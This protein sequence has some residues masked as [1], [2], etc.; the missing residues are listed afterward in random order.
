[1][2][3]FRR[4]LILLAFGLPLGVRAQT[5]LLSDMFPLAHQLSD[6]RVTCF[7]EDRFGFVWIGTRHGLNRFG[8]ATYLTYYAGKDSLSLSGDT[9][10]ALLQD[11]D[12]VWIGD[13]HGVEMI[14][15]G[16]VG[17]RAAIADHA[18]TAI[19]PLDEGMLVISDVNG[20]ALYDKESGQT[21]ASYE[22][23]DVSL[24]SAI[25]VTESGRVWVAGQK[26]I[27]FIFVFDKTLTLLRTLPLPNGTQVNGLEVLD[28][29]VYAA[30]TRG[31]CRF[32]TDG[33]QSTWIPTPSCGK[34]ILF[35]APARDSSGIV[36]GIASEGLRL[37]DKRK[38]WKT[39]WQEETLSGQGPYVC[40]V[41][42]DLVWLA[43]GRNGFSYEAIDSEIL[44]Y[45][46]P[47]EDSMVSISSGAE[48]GKVLVTSGRSVTLFDPAD[49]SSHNIT[50]LDI[51]P[52]QIITASVFDPVYS[53]LWLT[54]SDGAL[55]RYYFTS[56]SLTLQESYMLPRAHCLWLSKDGALHVIHEQEH[57]RIDASASLTRTPMGA[58][59]DF[60]TSHIDASG[61][62]YLYG[63][64]GIAIAEPDGSFRWVV[65]EGI[66]YVSCL[67]KDGRGRLWAGSFGE[68]L[69]CI[70][71][72]NIT[73]HLTED[74]GLPDL[75]VRALSL[76]GNGDLWVS[77]RYQVTKIRQTDLR[78]SVYDPSRHRDFTF[79]RACGLPLEDGS[80]LF[81]GS[82]LFFRFQPD[83]RKV[84]TAASPIFDGIFI[85]GQKQ[86]KNQGVV[87]RLPH[88]RN[89]VDFYYS[90]VD[91]GLRPGL[92]YR[93]KLEGYDKDWI[94]ASSSQR[95]GY[96]R[97]PAGRYTFS[98]QVLSP[99]GE[100]IQESAHPT[101]RIRPAPGR[102][103]PALLG[104]ILLLAL[105]TYAVY[106]QFLRLR[107]REERAEM[108]EQNRRITEKLSRDKEA[109]FMNISHEYRTPLTLIY[110]PAKELAESKGL[111]TH[112]QSLVQL[113]FSNA[114]RML[115][116]TGQLLQFD[117]IGQ[118]G[119]KLK[120]LNLDAAGLVRSVAANL[121]YI[122]ERK[123]IALE[124][125]A[126]EKLPAWCDQEKI[127]KILSNLLSNAA[128]YTEEGGQ[129]KIEA[130]LLRNDHARELYQLADS[131]YDGDWI[132]ISVKDNGIGI[133]KEKMERIFD[134]YER[135]HDK[136]DGNGFG[137]GLNFARELARLHKGGIKVEARHPKGT[138]FSFTFPAGKAAYDDMDIWDS[139]EAFRMEASDKQSIALSATPSADKPVLLVA[140]DND[141]MRDYL[142]SLFTGAFNVVGA[143]D[144]QEASDY[145]GLSVPDVVVSDVVMPYKDGFALCRQIKEDPRSSHIPVVLLTAK[146]NER[147]HLE[148]LGAGADAYVPKPF[149]PDIL[150]AT[151]DN[152]LR[153]RR[154]LQEILASR[155]S[156]T[157]EPNEETAVKL[158]SHDRKFIDKLY[159][160]IDEHI[161]E[162]VFNVSSLG[163]EL[164]MSRSNFHDK[165]KALL[166]ESPQTFLQTYR[167]NRAMELLREHDMNV[168]EVSY[169]VGFSSLSGFSRSFKRKFG[170]P[171]S[172]V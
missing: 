110:G 130:S 157:P 21:S 87:F 80:L 98:V 54:L 90:T 67:A 1:M 63:P 34:N 12:R 97:L 38:Q 147:N 27:P 171:P 95:A 31:I 55:R 135:L 56:G 88:D 134:R 118:Q 7:A 162:E 74:D 83:T 20:I 159:R 139:T 6:P 24:S 71:E 11:G 161:A 121:A 10:Y 170:I 131:D 48:N 111:S 19:A 46:I 76:D 57:V 105:A 28:N 32:S 165:C 78:M 13:E 39:I 43:D 160:L 138:R 133:P 108:A 26:G 92:Q 115:V 52:S 102:S 30:T 123:D 158:S 86:P 36:F 107:I 17:R 114:E 72:G 148:G 35:A 119:N 96:S 129:V 154:H 116:L 94:R 143:A 5:N 60:W 75:S 125:S 9:I 104:Y 79:Q 169:A 136:E 101:L 64:Y 127:E 151:V 145:L 2:I 112:Q 142:A 81:G 91:F 141:A 59:L 124:L 65:H 163:Q 144:G 29:A 58:E 82:D 132:E 152:L 126:P 42:E 120:I 140:E 16:T 150:L 172:S 14:E 149:S 68:G 93:Y 66:R 166:G 89:Q 18:V 23:R 85:N 113:I 62:V 168:S 41:G 45:R 77:T 61:T 3:N 37:L 47:G 100:I 44:M 51:L 167:L 122:F 103:V 117:K 84:I 8:G 146:D 99:E 33:T 15:R 109:F 40:H 164:G 153:N 49:G 73:R 53:N 137:L 50:P 156:A 128:K 69:Y 155:T 22:R 106:R 4:L 70:E 25:A